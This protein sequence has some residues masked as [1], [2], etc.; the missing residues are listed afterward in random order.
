[1]HELLTLGPFPL[2]GVR[3]PQEIITDA[4]HAARRTGGPVAWQVAPSGWRRLM[5]VLQLL[6]E[7][8]SGWTGA[9]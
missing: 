6:R 1:M 2:V 9:R 5:T 7:P 4:A 3:G 8:A